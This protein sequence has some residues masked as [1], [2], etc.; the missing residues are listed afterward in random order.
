VE[1]QFHRIEHSHLDGITEQAWLADR[2]AMRTLIEGIRRMPDIH[3]VEVRLDGTTFASA[4]QPI[5]E[6]G[7]AHEWTLRHEHRG[8]MQEIGQLT[9]Q[10][11][12]ANVRERLFQRAVF[13]V[14]ANLAMTVVVAALMYLVVHQVVTRH[15]ELI[16]GHF[17]QI[18]AD[19]LHTPLALDRPV[20]AERDE[21]DRLVDEYNHMRANLLI[22]YAELRELNATLE[23]RVAERTDA[24]ASPTPCPTTCGR[25]CGPSTVSPRSC[26]TAS[27]SVS[28]TRA[29]TCS[30]G[31]RATATSSTS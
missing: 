23:Q 20:Q 7:L 9:V 15:L 12:M 26:W 31:W 13:I 4:G 8:R 24:K 10:A 16:A 19:T 29:A 18:E 27:V 25:P 30:T 11:D 5:V 28:P 6:G 2:D 17:G 21:L 22:S 1:D 3:F 14:L